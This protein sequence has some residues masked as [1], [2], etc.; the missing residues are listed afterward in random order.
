MDGSL[1]AILIKFDLKN[2]LQNERELTRPMMDHRFII[3]HKNSYSKGRH[4]P[5]LF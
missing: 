2:I 5:L 4:S 1:D 3:R